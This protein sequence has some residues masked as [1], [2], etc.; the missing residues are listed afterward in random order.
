MGGGS[1]E[2]KLEME[3]QRSLGREGPAGAQR[4]KKRPGVKPPEQRTGPGD[5]V[6]GVLEEGCSGDPGSKRE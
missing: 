5:G 3:F 4:K 2:W 1:G 6:R